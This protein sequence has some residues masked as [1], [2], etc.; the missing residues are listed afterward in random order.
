MSGTLYLVAT[1]IGNLEDITPRA[2]KI[3][4]TVSTVL[5]EDTRNTGSLLAKLDI[6]AKMRSYHD[7]NEVHAAPHVIA[8]LEDGADIALVSD[9]GTPVIAD[10]GFVV[11][12]AAVAAGINVVPIPGPCAAISA[13]IASGLPPER[14]IF[15][16]F[17]PPKSGRRKTLMQSFAIERRTVVFYESPLP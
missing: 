9:A 8:E 4:E 17:L 1:P 7:H 10:P 2:R 16:N 12:R 13:L 14:F 6:K 11:V 5:A 3:L 15:E